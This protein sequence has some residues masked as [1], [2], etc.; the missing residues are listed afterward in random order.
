MIAMTDPRDNSVKVRVMVSPGRAAEVW[1]GAAAVWDP[2]LMKEGLLV[3]ICPDE[4]AIHGASRAAGIGMDLEKDNIRAS[5]AG[6]SGR[7]LQVDES[8]QTAKVRVVVSEG[9]AT[10]CWFAIAAIEPLT[11]R[12]ETEF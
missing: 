9:Q 4:I 12:K 3:Q 10:I 1:Y 7:V 2:K 8:D 5:C 11:P 6:K